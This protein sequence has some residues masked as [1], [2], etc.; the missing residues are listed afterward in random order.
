MPSPMPPQGA[1]AQ[2]EPAQ[3]PGGASQLV[4]QIHDGL[5]SLMDLMG[6]NPEMAPLAQKL[7]AVI[8]GYEGVVDELTQPQGQQGPQAPSPQGPSPMEAGSNP[9]ARP[10]Y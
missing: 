9:N 7:G 1:P 10:T 2:A 3:A 5:S 4:T 8:Q 6:K